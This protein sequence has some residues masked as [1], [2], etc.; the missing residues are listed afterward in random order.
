MDRLHQQVVAGGVV[1][2][3]GDAP[4]SRAATPA[5]LTEN[6]VFFTA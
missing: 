3:R 4:I 5:A 1:A 2:G 6:A